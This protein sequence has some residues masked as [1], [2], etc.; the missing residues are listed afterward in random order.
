MTSKDESFAQKGTMNLAT[1]LDPADKGTYILCSRVGLGWVQ[2]RRCVCVW[3]GG[4]GFCVN[5]QAFKGR[6]VRSGSLKCQAEVRHG[7]NSGMFT[8]I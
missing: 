7:E 2:W 4:G 5:S 6:L 3:G 8:R 1:V